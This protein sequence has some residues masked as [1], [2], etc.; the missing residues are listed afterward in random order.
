MLL[1]HI[2]LCLHVKHSLRKLK[3]RV[4]NVAK[5]FCY[6]ATDPR[7]LNQGKVRERRGAAAVT[8]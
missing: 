8:V 4:S 2:W 6:Q 5:A 7:G 3:A 1:Q